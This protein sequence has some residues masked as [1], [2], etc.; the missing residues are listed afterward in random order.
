M[1]KANEKLS[2][3]HEALLDYLLARIAGCKVMIEG[4]ERIMPLPASE[5]AVMAKIL[6]DNGI[7]ADK[8]H[9]DDLEKLQAQL[10]AEMTGSSNR[11]AILSQALDKIADDSGFMH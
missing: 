1:A 9:A 10:Q 7:V 4:E 8:D 2:A 11:E 5:L 6:K 3:L